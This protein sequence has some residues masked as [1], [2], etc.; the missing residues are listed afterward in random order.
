MGLHVGMLGAEQPAGAVPGDVLRFVNLLAAAI[1]AFCG[2]PFGIF[3]GKDRSHRHKDRFADHIFRG[4]QLDVPALPRQ[5]RLYGGAHLR[6]MGRE[7]LH[8]FFYHTRTHLSLCFFGCIC[9]IISKTKPE[10]NR[11]LC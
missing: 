1:V 4:D 10:Y 2:I 11:V 7:K 3:V 5:L 8:H 6:V 9:H